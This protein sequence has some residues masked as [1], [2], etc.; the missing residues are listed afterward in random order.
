MA[1]TKATKRREP[2]LD[3]LAHFAP[4]F[5]KATMYELEKVAQGVGQQRRVMLVALTMS[6]DELVK[7]S[8]DDQRSYSEMRDAVD[9]FAK[10]AEGLYKAARAAN[11]RTLAADVAGP[12][13]GG[14][15]REPKIK[16]RRAPQGAAA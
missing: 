13:I 12:P 14:K 15:H 5:D 10:H 6:A 3:E 11:L 4:A 16:T 9:G 1:K 8:K 2:T 7:W